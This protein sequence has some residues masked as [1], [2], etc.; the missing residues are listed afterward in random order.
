MLQRFLTNCLEGL[1]GRTTLV[2]HDIDLVTS[3]WSALPT[4]LIL[5]GLGFL[6]PRIC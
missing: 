5:A 6:N 3:W 1:T 4:W 2:D